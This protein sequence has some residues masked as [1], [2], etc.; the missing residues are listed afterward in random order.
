MSFPATLLPEPSDTEQTTLMKMHMLALHDAGQTGTGIG[1]S[2]TA[3]HNPPE[4]TYYTRIYALTDTVIASATGSVTGL[5][6]LALKAGS[7]IVGRFTE[8]KLTSGSVV[9]YIA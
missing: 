6:G 1:V 2:D 9:L 3:I 4:G 5:A 7:S 8:V